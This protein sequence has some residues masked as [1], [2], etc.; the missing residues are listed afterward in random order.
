MKML[1]EVKVKMPDSSWGYIIFAF[2]VAFL[3]FVQAV[4]FDGQNYRQDEINTIHAAQIYDY[5]GVVHWLAL[6][7]SHPPGWR[8]VAVAWT[9]S[10][11]MTESINRFQ[12][13][14]YTMIGLAL[15][16]RFGKDIFDE[17]V[18][19]MA[20]VV[21]GV[22]PFFQWYS[23][24]FRP[25]AALFMMSGML[26]LTFWRW[27]RHQDFQH[28]LL[29]V[30]VGVIGFQTHYFTLYIVAGQVVFVLLFWRWDKWLYL[31]AFGLFA[32]IGL[33]ITS[34]ILPILYGAFVF[35]DGGIVYGL[36]TDPASI[37]VL[38]LNMQG[39]L[40]AVVPAGVVSVKRVYPYFLTHPTRE[41]QWLRQS[42][43][44]RRWYPITLI[45]SALLISFT[46][47][48]FIVHITD[49]N[50]IILLMPTGI[51]VAFLFRALVPRWRWSV[52]GIFV[53]SSIL[54]FHSYHPDFPYR[55]MV[56]YLSPTY[57]PRDLILVSIADENPWALQYYLQD[58]LAGGVPEDHLLFIE[59]PETYSVAEID[60]AQGQLGGIYASDLASF[61]SNFLQDNDRGL[62]YIEY[63]S[64]DEVAGKTAKSLTPFYAEI[65][66]ANF[67]VVERAEFVVM[68]DDIPD[69]IVIV[70]KYAPKSADLRGAEHRQIFG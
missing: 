25:Y 42:I 2:I 12:S 37:L 32:A 47:N 50:L 53:L 14:L 44:W 15:L 54:N 64:Q 18:G 16:F 31:R 9:K 51:I 68:I 40:V 1:H 61:E 10:F 60:T 4:R 13:T 5:R 21:I 57:T 29:Y 67:I 36:T 35:R 3:I 27:F 6:D 56:A 41:D 48:A 62:W 22:L 33:S 59:E 38:L 69:G 63:I 66:A 52:M 55:Q 46:F 58:H 17:Q 28:A 19:L 45:M 7:G 39:I 34:W 30:L 24:E 8:V 70:T 11:G 26:T 49:R 65:L 43:E 23:H 20:V